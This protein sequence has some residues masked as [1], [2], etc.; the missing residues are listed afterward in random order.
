MYTEQRLFTKFPTK[1]DKKVG[2]KVTNNKAGSVMREKM[3][4]FLVS[5][6]CHQKDQHQFKPEDLFGCESTGFVFSL[7]DIFFVYLL[8]CLSQYFH[9]LTQ[10]CSTLYAGFAQFTKTV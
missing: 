1:W 7:L 4:V 10:F 9:G 2:K 5:F 3:N 6:Y 8:V